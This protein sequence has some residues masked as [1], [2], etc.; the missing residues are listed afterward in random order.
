MLCRSDVTVNE[1]CIYRWGGNDTCVQ[2]NCDSGSNQC[3]WFERNN[4]NFTFSTVDMLA[5][6]IG[7]LMARSHY[8]RWVDEVGWNGGPIVSNIVRVRRL[9]L[10]GNILR[11]PS[12]RPAGVTMQWEPH[13][14]RR[15]RG[16]SRNT[17]QQTFREHLQEMWVS[18]SSVCRVA[19]YGSRWKSLVCCQ[20]CQQEWEELSL[21]KVTIINFRN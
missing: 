7:R 19:S 3:G 5:C 17:W 2:I 21:S 9:T 16:C 10:A 15:R 20:V 14:G 11:L 18:W 12:D 1:V 4:E 6:Q 13:R 8:W